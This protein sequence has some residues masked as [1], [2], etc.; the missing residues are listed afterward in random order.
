MSN[1]QLLV[2]NEAGEDVVTRVGYN[3]VE[4]TKRRP[5]GYEYKGHR[6]IRIARATG[7]EI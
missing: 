7:E 5:D 2:K 3:R 6:S 1:V 4:A